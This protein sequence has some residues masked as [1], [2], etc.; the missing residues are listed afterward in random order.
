MTARIESQ[1]DASTCGPTCLH[2]LYRHYG[3]D[4]ALAAVIDSIQRLD[5]GGTLDVYLASHAL[6]RGYTSTIYTYNLEVFDPTW[7][8]RKTDLAAKL[9]DQAKAKPGRRLATAT[10]GYLEYLS[11]GGKLRFKDLTRKL[12]RQ[13]LR[14]GHPALTGLS[15]TYL[16]GSMREWGPEDVDDDIRG[17]PVGH[18][19]LLTGYDR[20]TC[21][22]LIADPMKENPHG[23]QNYRI[24]IDRVIG[25]ILLGAV[26]YDANLVVIRPG[27]P[28][29]R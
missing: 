13:V 4:V 19:V 23:S 2:A 9:L 21:Q 1:P 22:V 20:S 17:E 14:D 27:G 25:A 3:D 24:H 28:R 29:T 16:Y 7:F 12:I 5:H 8:D 6:T 26:T 10:R 11:L 15:A 18:F